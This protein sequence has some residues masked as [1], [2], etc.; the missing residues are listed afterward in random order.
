MKL[1]LAPH[2]LIRICTDLAAITA[3]CVIFAVGATKAGIGF[4]EQTD[5]MSHVVTAQ[6]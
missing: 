1:L 6:H 4:D 3:V 2:R 5:P